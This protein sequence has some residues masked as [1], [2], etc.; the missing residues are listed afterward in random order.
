MGSARA[1]LI[2]LSIKF[3]LVAWL[4][5]WMP[6]RA[7]AYPPV[8]WLSF[9]AY[10]SVI[11]VAGV[12]SENRLLVSWQAVALLVGQAA[13]AIDAVSRGPATAYL[14]DDGVPFAVRSLSLFHF[15][16]PLVA[17]DAVRRLGYDR[18]AMPLQVMTA[19]I[20]LPLAYA[21]DPQSLAFGGA[22]SIETK[23]PALILLSV[24][25]LLLIFCY[26]PAH[27][28]LAA[29]RGSDS[30][31]RRWI[32]WRSLSVRAARCRQLHERRARWRLS[33]G[34]PRSE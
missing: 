12:V 8:S 7:V 19:A 29:G 5:V 13:Y 16:M 21:A 24:F 23:P 6:L 1:A 10:G 26:A 32:S 14:F 30:A 9:C 18:R 17:L 3:A 28:V 20:V 2:P 27:A 4:L 31:A 15:V 25:L 33:A 34:A 11:L 22:F